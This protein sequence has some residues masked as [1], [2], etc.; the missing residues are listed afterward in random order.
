[1]SSRSLVGGFRVVILFLFLTKEHRGRESTIITILTENPGL[2]YLSLYIFTFFQRAEESEI[3]DLS[4]IKKQLMS[5][6]LCRLGSNINRQIHE[7]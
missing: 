1:M 5:V 2:N 4:N 7:F 3:T 6:G